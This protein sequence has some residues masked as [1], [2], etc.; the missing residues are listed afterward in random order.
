VRELLRLDLRYYSKA[1]PSI[2]SDTVHQLR[3]GIHNIVARGSA[4]LSHLA[5]KLRLKAFWIPDRQRILLDADEP[6]LKHRWNEAHEI[7]HSIIP[8][9]AMLLH[10]D[11]QRT[12]QPICHYYVE[13][14]ANYAAG[15]LLFLQ[16]L[17]VKELMDSRADLDAVKSLK[18]R[19][20]N[21]LTATLWRFVEHLDVPALGVVSVHPRYLPQNF[22]WVTLPVLHPLTRI[23]F[24]VY[25]G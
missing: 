17:F 11:N 10:G 22:D 9:H 16:D 8:W 20:G 21:T 3:L 25:T 13:A 4:A 1:D 2:L 24:A 7:G 19:F 5:A 12:L 6:P 18:S 14:E 23:R 15:R